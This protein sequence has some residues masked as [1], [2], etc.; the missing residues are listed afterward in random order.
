MDASVASAT[1]ATFVAWF[2][3]RRQA[4]LWCCSSAYFNLTRCEYWFSCVSPFP[5]GKWVPNPAAARFK[6]N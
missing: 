4:K 5:R 1:L 2:E 6:I 3:V